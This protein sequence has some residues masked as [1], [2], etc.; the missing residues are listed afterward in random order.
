MVARLDSRSEK[1]NKTTGEQQRWVPFLVKRPAT[2]I[3]MGFSKTAIPEYTR[4]YGGVN[5][6]IF[7]SF[8]H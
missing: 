8:L 2:L 3:K 1:L 7:L 5:I 6:Y 4:D